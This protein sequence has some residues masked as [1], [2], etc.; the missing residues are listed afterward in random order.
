MPNCGVD[1]EGRCTRACGH[2]VHHSLL[3]HRVRRLLGKGRRDQ[4]NP[5]GHMHLPTRLVSGISDDA[6]AGNDYR[7]VSVL[8]AASQIA[9]HHMLSLTIKVMIADS[10]VSS[11]I[12]AALRRS[13]EAVRDTLRLDHAKPPTETRQEL[14]V[15]Q[16]VLGQEVTHP[17]TIARTRTAAQPR[18]LNHRREQQERGAIHGMDD[19]ERAA[20]DLGDACVR[21][22]QEV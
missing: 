1:E 2:Y 20:L 8:L 7:T 11:C 16:G 21:Q 9:L 22:G 4:T 15:G 5:L 18:T 10:D 6:T 14:S 17:L 19:P 12:L 3:D 13:V